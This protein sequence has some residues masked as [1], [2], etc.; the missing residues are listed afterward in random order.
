MKPPQSQD[1]ADSPL[2]G[3][4]V[5]DLSVTLP[6]PYATQVLRRLGATVVHLEP[7]G[8]DSLRYG[9]PASHAFLAE[10]KE[11]V[12]VNLKDPSDRGFALS[13]L[14]GA[15]IVVEGWR[16]GV[17]QRLGVGYEH[18]S[19]RNPAVVYCSITGYGSTGPM[20]GR[21]GHDINYTAAS[22]ALDMLRPDGMPVGDLAGANA[23][24]TRILAELTRAA[25]TRR[26]RHVEVSITGT[27]ADWVG[28]L[29]GREWRQFAQIL[30]TPHYAEYTTKDGERLVLGVAPMEQAFWE[31]VITVMGRPEWA[32]LTYEERRERHDELTAHLTE[33]V[34]ELT[35]AEIADRLSGADTCWSFAREPGTAERLAGRLPARPGAVPAVDEHGARYREIVSRPE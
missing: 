11:S 14:A 19:A 9:A 12:V 15:D 8:G 3:V 7:P 26:G 1:D 17:A 27:L 31:N 21:A 20:A 23:A 6:G 24:V 4:H 33:A 34:R 22:G 25:R 2:A 32:V 13:L 30:H 28:A 16:P 10:G 35:A 29:G 18:V 5:V